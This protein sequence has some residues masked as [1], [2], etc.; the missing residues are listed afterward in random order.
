MTVGD[1]V[2]DPDGAPH[3]RTGHA[4]GFLH[5]K[6]DGVILE[7]TA[8]DHSHIEP[9]AAQHE[10]WS[11]LRR[12][13]RGECDRSETESGK[14]IEEGDVAQSTDVCIRKE[15][16]DGKRQQIYVAMYTGNGC[17]F[18]DA[19]AK[20]YGIRLPDLHTP[21][22]ITA[23]VDAASAFGIPV[24]ALLAALQSGNAGWHPEP[25]AA[26]ILRLY[27][28]CA[29]RLIQYRQAL[30][31][32][33]QTEAE[34]MRRMRAWVPIGFDDLLT[35]TEP[36]AAYAFSF[37]A[38]QRMPPDLRE[39]IAVGLRE[40]WLRQHGCIRSHVYTARFTAP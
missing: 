13:V 20:N 35:H 4:F 39:Q 29:D 36:P 6:S 8:W 34:L 9:P 18:F 15:L 17:V 22:P 24:R 32:P 30:R 11:A 5:Y 27:D 31:P 1:A 33:Q 26:D 7:G 38:D 23:G 19:G 16:H 14:H 40:G 2:F 28:A 10:K 12:C 3:E 37:V 25:G 21:L